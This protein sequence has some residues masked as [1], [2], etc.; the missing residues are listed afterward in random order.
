MWMVFW[1][2]NPACMYVHIHVCLYACA[3]YLLA[4]LVVH[5]SGSRPKF[6]ARRLIVVLSLERRLPLLNSAKPRRSMRNVEAQQ[7]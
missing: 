7:S 5:C 6:E 1:G 2:L 4:H 3:C